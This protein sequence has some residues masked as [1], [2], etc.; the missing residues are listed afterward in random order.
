LRGVETKFQNG[1]TAGDEERD[2]LRSSHPDERTRLSGV[3]VAWR[4]KPLGCAEAHPY[5]FALTRTKDTTVGRKRPL[6][7]GAEGVFVQ[8]DFRGVAGM[9]VD[10]QDVEAARVVVD[11]PLGE[12][13]QGGADQDALLV[14]GDA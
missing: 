2:I 12:E 9:V 10:G 11:A 7:L 1:K 13:T 3:L 6:Q 5:N 4:L 8:A 14:G